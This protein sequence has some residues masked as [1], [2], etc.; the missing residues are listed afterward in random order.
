LYSV[1]ALVTFSFF[2]SVVAQSLMAISGGLLLIINSWGIWGLRDLI[3]FS[4]DEKESKKNVSV[5]V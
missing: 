2:D 5:T 3:S 4:L 1:P